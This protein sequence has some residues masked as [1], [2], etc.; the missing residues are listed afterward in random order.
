MSERVEGATLPPRKRG[1]EP[2][3]RER[4][5]FEQWFDGAV[6]RLRRGEDFDVTPTSMRGAIYGAAKRR[7]YKVETR[8]VSGV[9]MVQR[10]GDLE[11]AE[12][13]G[14]S[15]KRKGWAFWR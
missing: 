8:I 13:D 2:K 15:A 1:K 14:T 5:P 4:Y 3:G 12:S 7:G 6:W 11:V 10:T 9:V